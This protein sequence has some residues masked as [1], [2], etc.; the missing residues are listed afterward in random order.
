MNT[1]GISRK[2]RI[3]GGLWGAVTG[4]ALGVPVEFKSRAEV[5]ADPVT[6]MRG[7]GTHQ[8]P[9]GTWSDDSSLLLCSADSLL[10]H[11]FNTEDMGQRFV[12]WYQEK[13]WTPWGKVFDVGVTTS[14]ALARIANGVRAEVAGNDDQYSNGNGSLMRIL[15]VTLRFTEQPVPALLE[16]VHRASAVTHRHARS[17]MACGFYALVIRELLSGAKVAD[18]FAQG[19]ESFRSF[20]EPDPYWAV[21]LD[22]FQLAMAKDLAAR[23]EPEID[24]SGY[25]VH[26]LTASLWCLLTTDNYHDCVLKA[27]NLGGD[28]DTTGCVAGGLAGVAYGTSAVPQQWIEQLARRQE[29]DQLFKTFSK[30][31]QDNT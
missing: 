1:E 6:N 9:A 5:Q 26:T 25:V 15:P 11:D 23:P 24:S 13:L 18:A 16:R 21:E 31:C 20:Y 30:L 10:R 14:Q 4:D 22:Y 2:D 7:H 8:Q 29:L 27:V 17:Q 28:T 3:L 12:A 19:V